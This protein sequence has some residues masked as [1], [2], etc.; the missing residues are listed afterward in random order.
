MPE[1]WLLELVASS[2]HWACGSSHGRY[3]KHK[4]LGKNLANYPPMEVD[5]CHN[6]EG[7]LF[8]NRGGF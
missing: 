6:S 8:F 5:Q 1:Q 7:C 3:A 2:L 4:L